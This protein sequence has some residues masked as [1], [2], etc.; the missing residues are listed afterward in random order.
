[1]I[2][3]EAELTIS[4]YLCLV[5]SLPAQW[6]ERELSSFIILLRSSSTLKESI[7]RVMGAH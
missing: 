3:C 5:V 6:W 2:M 1:M 7:D 4:I